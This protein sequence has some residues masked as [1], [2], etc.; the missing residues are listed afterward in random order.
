[1]VLENPGKTE[2]KVKK[3]MHDFSLG[4]PVDVEEYTGPMVDG[5]PI[6]SGNCEDGVYGCRKCGSAAKKLTDE[7]LKALGWSTSQ[8]CDWCKK[9]T[10]IKEISGIRPWDEPSC[11]YEVCRD[12][13]RKYNAELLKEIEY[14]EARYGSY[15]L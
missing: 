12:C 1:M 3:N 14:D 6:H 5:K 9:D 15:D 4:G 11:Y 7:Q 2:R 8:F 10:P 13:C